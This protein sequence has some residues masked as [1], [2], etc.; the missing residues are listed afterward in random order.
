MNN[1]QP[2]ATDL[3]GSF[4]FFLEE[5]LPLADVREALSDFLRNLQLKY[6]KQYKQLLTAETRAHFWVLF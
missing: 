2:S 1:V 4:C 5:G 3:I 6:D